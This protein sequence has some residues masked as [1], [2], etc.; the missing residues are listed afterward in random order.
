MTKNIMIVRIWVIGLFFSILPSCLHIGRSRDNIV[1]LWK[2]AT[3]SPS[4]IT[5]VKCASIEFFEDGKF[6]AYNLPRDYFPPVNIPIDPN[7]RVDASGRWELKPSSSKDP[8]ANRLL[9][10]KVDPKPESLEYNTAM[11]ITTVGQPMLYTDIGNLDQAVIF[12]KD[13]SD[14]CKEEP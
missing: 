11:L 3:Y 14:W 12:T 13:E 2:E 8:L 5:G 7:I 1:G 4:F 6:E 10:I 9:E